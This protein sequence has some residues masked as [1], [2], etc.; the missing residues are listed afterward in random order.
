MQY[1]QQEIF[2]QPKFRSS[3]TFTR[4][5]SNGYKENVK[6]LSNEMTFIETN[7]NDIKSGETV[8]KLVMNNLVKMLKRIQLMLLTL[9]KNLN[10]KKKKEIRGREIRRSH[11]A[12]FKVAVTHELQPGVT[13][14]QVTDKYCI[15]QSLVSKW[16]KE[17]DSIIAPATN[18]HKKLFAKQ[19]EPTK[20]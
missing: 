14:D 13:Q 15:N 1:L 12:L 8:R 16:Y 5:K 2:K 6:P 3:Q 18:N 7:S 4:E 17:K 9:N 20:Y 11:T 10:K 19:R